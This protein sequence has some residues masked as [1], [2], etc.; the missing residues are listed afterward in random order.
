MH[1]LLPLQLVLKG[2]SSNHFSTSSAGKPAKGKPKGKPKRTKDKP[3]GPPTEFAWYHQA[4]VVG[5]LLGDGSAKLT[6]RNWLLAFGQSNY[7][8]I[9]WLYD[10]FKPWINTRMKPYLYSDL[11]RFN[12]A[13]I[14]DIG[15]ICR[16]FYPD[17]VRGALGQKVVPPNI[18]DLLTSPLALAVWYMGDGVK[19]PDGGFTL[20][21]DSFSVADIELLRAMLAT[22]LGLVHTSI[23]GRYGPHP[24]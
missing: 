17:A 6:G 15:T 2:S 19:H 3:N 1:W 11:W 20:C 8:F 22:N 7:E 13:V 14:L 16:L 9:T 12:T 24:R 5:H 18:M 21:T 23:H 10:V 4:I